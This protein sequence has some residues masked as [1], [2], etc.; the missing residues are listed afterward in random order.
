LVKKLIALIKRAA[1]GSPFLVFLFN[2]DVSSKLPREM[3]TRNL[4]LLLF[5]ILAVSPLKSQTKADIRDMFNQGE[6]YILFEE[7]NEALPS[8]QNLLKLS[9]DNANFKYRIGQ[10]YL[11]IPGEKEKAIPYLED[12][13]Q[14]I[15]PR[16]KQGRIKEKSAPYDALYYLANA[17][18]INNQLDKAIETYELFIQ[19]MDHRVYDSTI[20]NFQLQTC[21]NAKQMMT[22][23]LFVRY[24]NLGE[25]INERFLETNPVIS[26][27]DDLL[28]FSRKLQF[29]TALFYSRLTDGVW[30]GP[31]D[32]IPD[33]NVDDKFY[34]TSLSRDG[35]TLYLYSNFDYIGNIYTSRFANGRWNPV[36]KLNENVNT[37]YWES[38]AT[39]SPDGRK[40]FFSS[41][42]K[43]GYG[44][45]DIYVSELDSIGNWGLARNLGPVINTPY[46]EDTP[47]LSEDGK[48]LF[49][50]SRGHYNMGGYDIFY[51]T[52]VNG[53]EWSIPLNAGYPLNTTDD[54]LFFMPLGKGYEGYIARFDDQGFGEQDIYRVEI[55]SDDHPRRFLIRGI[56]RI[57]DLRKDVAAGI[58]LIVRDITDSQTPIIVYADPLTGK[59]EFEVKHGEYEITF[60]ADG[61]VKEVKKLSLPLTMNSDTVAFPP[62]VLEKND[63]EA[64][65][66]IRT[67]SL[68]R[69]KGGD[70]A[71]I[72]LSTEP[73][74]ILD[75]LITNE[76]RQIAS[77]RFNIDD[78]VF[79]YRFVP[80]PG[81]NIVDFR[82][83]DMFSNTATARVIVEKDIL[84]ATETITR[85]EYTRVIAER[86][87]N[88]FLE[89]LK[90]NADE[91]IRKI[92]SGID[93][94][95]ERFG[96]IDDVVS[97]LNER[98]GRKI[99]E[100][101][102]VEKLALETAVKDN[103]LTQAAV[104]YLEKRADGELK[105]ILSGINIYDLRLKTWSDL[106][107]YISKQ[108]EGRISGNDLDKLADYLLTGADGAIAI[109]K[110]KI[111]IYAGLQED[112]SAIKAAVEEADRQL[113][114]DKGEWLN[115][116]IE[117]A[118]SKGLTES[119][120]AKLLAAITFAPSTSL[121]DAVAQLIK[122]SNA[123]LAGYLGEMNLKGIKSLEELFG[124]LLS[125]RGKSFSKDELY[126]ALAATIAENNLAG[127]LIAP[128]A[129]KSRLPIFWILGPL[130]GAII[131]FLVITRKKKKKKETRN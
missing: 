7:Y 26:A 77:D 54:D 84:R 43:G 35:N 90:R 25:N 12:A 33:L 18:R 99:S 62:V 63:F 22:T 127:E 124:L 122:N 110:E 79:L 28:F 47:T 50:S 37:K 117:G 24:T 92:I 30:S 86:Q 125:E 27:K 76:G 66:R 131:L 32:I 3:K 98:A 20:V 21:H 119:D 104:D 89:I 41:N 2:L 87:A 19:N 39:V 48:T 9:P 85:P 120:L 60:D 112:P 101:E 94:K 8:F 16:H 6:M 113:I 46:H 97:L 29:R 17:Y 11:N 67:D 59:Y 15:N 70:T 40:L 72:K 73:K 36:Q 108:S 45:L 38:H 49:F 109:M 61:V 126:S 56:T 111:G 34:P 53:E 31:I 88:A 52:Q 121:S 69:V 83:T 80:Q 81:K 130:A 82:L 5:L 71:E 14:N 91:E 93:A 103:I 102:G 115:A 75:V 100:S 57:E 1:S 13:V 51:S 95:K 68:L 44:G 106:K 23:P 123:A 4:C 114:K 42:R 105:R 128:P 78:T 55:Y 96:N 129:E 58:R 65:L 107:D 10:C 64:D 116:F 118:L 74:S